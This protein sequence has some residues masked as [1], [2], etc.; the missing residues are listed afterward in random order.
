MLKV[1]LL[2]YLLR[3]VSFIRFKKMIVEE[4]ENNSQ[5]SKFWQTT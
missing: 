5:K 2:D 3:I 1:A 4:N